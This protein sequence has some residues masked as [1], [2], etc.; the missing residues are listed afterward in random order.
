MGCFL[1]DYKFLWRLLQD[2]CVFRAKKTAFVMQ[3]FRN[4]GA[5]GSGGD[6]FSMKPPKGTFLA[7]FTRFEPLHIQII[8]RVFKVTER[9]YFTYLQGIPH[10]TKFN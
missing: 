8:S 5:S 1:F 6:H 2:L 7:D 3:N 9:L 10:S 4:L